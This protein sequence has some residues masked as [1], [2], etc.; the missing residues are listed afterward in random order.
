MSVYIIRQSH[1]GALK[2]GFSDEPTRRLKGLQTAS[3]YPLELV[4]LLN[5]HNYPERWIHAQLAPWQMEGEWFEPTPEVLAFVEGLQSR[6]IEPPDREVFFGRI[7]PVRVLDDEDESESRWAKRPRR[8]Q[9]IRPKRPTPP[10]E[11]CRVPFRE[12]ASL[13]QAILEK[14]N[15]SAS[16][17]SE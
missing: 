4:C 2:I 11:P 6:A 13:A 17:S 15:D 1:T 12:A 3:P 14:L 8:S 10:P 9:Y 5:P 16:D 7:I